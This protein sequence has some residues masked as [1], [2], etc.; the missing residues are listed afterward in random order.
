ME[1][2][3]LSAAVRAAI[4]SPLL[5]SLLDGERSTSAA[6]AQRCGLDPRTTHAVLEVLTS[7]G[8]C[9]R[10]GDSFVA[11]SALLA[12]VKS[13]P[14]GVES[15]L[16][17]WRHVPGM[18]KSGAS[19]GART[20][21]DL[22]ALY[23]G[24]TSRLATMFRASSDAL[25]AQLLSTLPRPPARVLDLGCGSGVWGLALAAPS[26][27]HFVG[28]DRAPVLDTLRAHAAERGLADRVEARAGD[29]F[30]ASLED[31]HYDLVVVANVIRLG[32][33]AFARAVLERA[34]QACAKDG[35]VVVVDAFA[36][37]SEGAERARTAYGL[38]L[39]A[40][41]VEGRVYRVD[42]VTGWLAAC[43]L[44]KSTVYTLQPPAGAIVGQRA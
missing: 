4:D 27:A 19:V 43:G 29:L 16:T 8:L 18:L 39:V 10:D 5:G 30:S 38:H 3:A 24:V 32:N 37:G 14:G 1:A 22:G 42:E 44:G 9:V 23:K 15:D 25:A 28:V 2:L 11:S 20:E 41:S 12:W 36:T 33:E 13:T 17:I 31:A 7:A 35:A 21:E 6:R 40:R 34:A 26:R